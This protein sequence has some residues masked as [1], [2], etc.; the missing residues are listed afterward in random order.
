MHPLLFSGWQNA[1]TANKLWFLFFHEGKPYLPM[2]NVALN[3]L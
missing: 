2:A 3:E 1:Q